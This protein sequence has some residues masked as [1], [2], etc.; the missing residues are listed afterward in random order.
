MMAAPSDVWSL[1]EVPGRLSGKLSWE[2][3]QE[4]KAYAD[5]LSKKQTIYGR[6]LILVI[7]TPIDTSEQR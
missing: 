2:L 7:S 1:T 3:W 6:R 4:T 5:A